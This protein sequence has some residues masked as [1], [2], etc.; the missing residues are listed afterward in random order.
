MPLLPRKKNAPAIPP[1]M[2]AAI[3][4]APMTPSAARYGVPDPDPGLSA[5]Y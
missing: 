4:D 5:A 2:A 1:K 3:A